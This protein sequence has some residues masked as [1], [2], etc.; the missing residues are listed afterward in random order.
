MNV[1]EIM[2]KDVI[3]VDKD[4]SLARVLDLMKKYEITK[5]PV[6]EQKKF[7]G[8][9]TDNI[10]AYKL[11]SFR[12]RGV[13]ASRLH[14]SSVTEKNIESVSPKTDVKTILRKVGE[15]GPTM[16]PVMEKEK[17]VGVV[18]KADMLPLVTSRKPVSTILQTTVYTV[19]SEDRVVHARR[20]MLDN[21][22]ARLPVV[23]RGRLIGMISDREVA[24]A[25]ASLKKSITLGKQKHKLEELLVKDIMKTPAVWIPASTSIMDAAKIMMRLNV[26]AL[27]VLKGENL[28]GIISRT[29]V[30]KTVSL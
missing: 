9:V 18:T 7:I 17:L 10:I 11:G 6:V 16:L 15:P 1:E 13:T 22:V 21:E 30:L 8:I 23:Y 3:S 12:K 24:F 5:I 2:T 27:P 4:E 29:D 14:A 28:I 19:S 25:F 26:G 20:M